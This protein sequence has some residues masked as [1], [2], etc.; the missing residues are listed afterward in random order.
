M[1]REVVMVSGSRLLV[2]STRSC[3]CSSDD[4]S[5]I[6]DEDV[7]NSNAHLA[8]APCSPLSRTGT[9]D[10]WSLDCATVHCR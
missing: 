8:L 7:V 5:E 1:T 9:L 4:R 3:G 6:T 10:V 2:H